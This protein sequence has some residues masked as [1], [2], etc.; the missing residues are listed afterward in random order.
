VSS[1]KPKQRH[2]AILGDQELAPGEVTLKD[3]HGGEQRSLAEDGM[4]QAVAG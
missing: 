4:L 3:L 1:L 2:T